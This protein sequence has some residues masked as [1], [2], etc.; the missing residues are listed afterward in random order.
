MARYRL[1]EIA[2][3]AFGVAEP[4]VDHGHVV[5]SGVALAGSDLQFGDNLFS[6]YPPAFNGE[7]PSEP[8]QTLGVAI[9]QHDSLSQFLHCL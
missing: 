9:G 4:R 2:Q 5:G 8:T 6:L 3:G 1:V 7:H